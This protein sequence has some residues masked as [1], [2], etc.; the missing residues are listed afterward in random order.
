MKPFK[1]EVRIGSDRCDRNARKAAS[2]HK[3]MDVVRAVLSDYTCTTGT[4]TGLGDQRDE[5]R[6]RA[7]AW[8]TQPSEDDELDKPQSLQVTSI[9]VLIHV[10]VIIGYS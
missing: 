8:A 7:S 9:L 6:E 10:L 1:I 2:K 4:R 5:L 3:H